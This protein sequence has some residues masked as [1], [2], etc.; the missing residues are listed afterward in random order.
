MPTTNQKIIEN[1][2]FLAKEKGVSFT[3]VLK[4]VGINP[5]FKYDLE[6][7]SSP[8]VDKISRL[9]EYFGV[10]MARIIEG[11]NGEV[12]AL[13]ALYEKLSPESKAELKSYMQ[14]L[15]QP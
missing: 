5:N 2:R 8:S 15:I 12:S 11:E 7:G 3:Q 10:S 6:H 13:L 9:A 4:D 14:S 1:I